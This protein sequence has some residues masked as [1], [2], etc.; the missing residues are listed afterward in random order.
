[1]SLIC[2]VCNSHLTNHNYSNIYSYK[3]IDKTQ[4]ATQDFT[5]LSSASQISNNDP[6]SNLSQFKSIGQMK[7]FT[8]VAFVS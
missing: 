3:D 5:Q 8:K 4:G 7:N 1:M 2:V 6:F